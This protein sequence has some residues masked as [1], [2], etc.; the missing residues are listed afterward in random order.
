MFDIRRLN[1]DVLNLLHRSH[2]VYQISYIY[3]T[4]GFRLTLHLCLFFFFSQLVNIIL[5]DDEDEDFLYHTQLSSTSSANGPHPQA[6]NA[7]GRTFR[8]AFIASFG[9]SPSCC[10]R[11]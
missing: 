4:D 2:I 5:D 3:L 1:C 11:K 6:V 10:M 7:M 9:D 8:T